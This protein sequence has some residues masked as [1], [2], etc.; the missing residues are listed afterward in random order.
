MFLELVEMLDGYSYIASDDTD[1][2]NLVV[3]YKENQFIVRS[4][5][6]L[7]T[8]SVY[9]FAYRPPQRIELTFLGETP[10]DFTLINMHLKCCD[11]GFDRRVASASILHEYLNSSVNS[12]I[13]NHIV[14]GELE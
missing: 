4:Q 1:Y 10:F 14:V 3:L 7:F 2:L 6:S 9:E 12:G 13:M 8:D 11:D 5:Q